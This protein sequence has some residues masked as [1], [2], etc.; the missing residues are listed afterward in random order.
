LL[1]RKQLGVNKIK[2]KS[3]GTIERYKARL[4]A[5]GY[6]Q[7]EGLDYH[8]T[9]SPIAK[10]T[11][12]Q[13]LLAVAASKNWFLHQLDVNNAFLYDGL[14]EEVYMSVLPG[15]GIKGESQVC[16]LKKSLY[17]LKQASRQ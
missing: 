16:K 1:E 2:L 3:D 7:C 10:L 13:C 5:K 12:I 9:F 14:D 8:E 6:T 15:F 4:V 17:G 11:T